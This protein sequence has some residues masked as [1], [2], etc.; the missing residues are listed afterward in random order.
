MR[1]SWY[2]IIIIIVII[3]IR[4]RTVNPPHGDFVLSVV[5]MCASPNLDILGVKFDSTFTF[6]DHVLGIVSCV[7]Q[8][9]GILR[10]V[11]PVFVATSV[12][13]RCPSTSLRSPNP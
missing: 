13:L 9:I 4:S 6:E 1:K 8:R 10:L 3:I 2:I 12:L 11:K 7:S 5:S